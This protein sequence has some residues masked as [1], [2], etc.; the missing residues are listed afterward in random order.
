[1]NLQSEKTLRFAKKALESHIVA[2]AADKGIKITKA[3]SQIAADIGV[4]PSS[5][6]QFLN[7]EVIKPAPKTMQKYVDWLGKN[8]ETTID[9]RDEKPQPTPKEITT[10]PVAKG[11]A[12]LVT[13]DEV[14]MLIGLLQA[15]ESSIRDDYT[16]FEEDRGH[17][18]GREISIASYQ[19]MYRQ[20]GL[21][22]RLRRKIESQSPCQFKFDTELQSVVPLI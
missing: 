16:G 8:P 1:M 18:W 19:A 15:S 6:R 14:A 13:D 20:E 12:L 10:S 7:G 9:P 3:R 21:L 17:E 4:D 5:I 22:K 11:T 2:L